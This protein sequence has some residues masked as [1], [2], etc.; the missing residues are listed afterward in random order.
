MSENLNSKTKKE[1]FSL[2]VIK[3]FEITNF[4]STNS[5]I[6]NI[7][8][9]FNILKSH[10]DLL[11]KLYRRKKRRHKAIWKRGQKRYKSYDGA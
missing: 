9:F 2:E 5:D 3:D 10:T 11:Y 7:F 1:N 6:K 4:Y 8:E